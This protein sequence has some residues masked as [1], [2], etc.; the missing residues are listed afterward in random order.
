MIRINIIA[1]LLS[2]PS[3]DGHEIAALPAE[4]DWLE[5]C[6]ELTGDLVPDWL[7]DRFH[8]RLLYSPRSHSDEPSDHRHERLRRAARSFDLVELETGRDC[9]PG[10]LAQIPAAQRLVSWHGPAASLRDLEAAFA[11][12]ASVPAR[13]YKL[14]TAAARTAFAAAALPAGAL[15]MLEVVAA[16]P[17]EG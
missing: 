1:T 11:R 10:L 5:V 4:V 9:S 12:I 15:V 6:P 14:T 7:R 8:G 13:L 16:Y 17:G 3:A 2:P